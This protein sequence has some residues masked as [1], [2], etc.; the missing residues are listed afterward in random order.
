MF[1][2]IIEKASRAIIFTVGHILAQQIAQKPQKGPPNPPSVKIIPLRGDRK[3]MNFPW[4]R[5]T[6]RE[7]HRN[8]PHPLLNG[9]N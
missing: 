5:V 8:I 4:Y 6:R 2:V 3:A 7:I 1:K 9:H